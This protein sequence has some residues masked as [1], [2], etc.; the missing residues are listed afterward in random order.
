MVRKPERENKFHWLIKLSDSETSL[1]TY[2]GNKKALTSLKDVT[3]EVIAIDRN[4]HHQLILKGYPNL[5]E[6][7]FIYTTSKEQAVALVLKHRADYFMANKFILNWRLK[8]AKVNQNAITEA[9]ELP[10]QG[11]ELYIAASLDT[12]PKYLEE[13]KQAYAQL[14]ANGEIK[15]IA[16]KWF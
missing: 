9:F 8:L 11:N 13:I 15:T 2:Q 4:D 3:D 16:D 6:K 12:S 5:V 7:N 1:W 10:K 14:Q